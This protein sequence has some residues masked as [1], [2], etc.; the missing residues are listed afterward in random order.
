MPYTKQTRF[1]K[2]AL[3]FLATI[4]LLIATFFIPMPRWA[5][6]L[7]DFVIV[8]G[9]M[10]IRRGYVFFSQGAAYFKAGQEEKAMKKLRAAV[11]AG[12]GA[13]Y[14]IS[15]ASVFV[16]KGAVDEG[17]EILEK[18]LTENNTVTDTNRAKVALSMGK[19]VKGD[20]QRAVEL[21]EQVKE[22]GY[23]DEGLYVNLSTYLLS[24]NQIDK[25]KKV[26]KEADEKGVAL[27]A[28]DDNRGWLDIINGRW[29]KAEQIFDRLINEECVTFPEPYVHGAQ[30]AVHKNEPETAMTYLSWCLARPFSFTSAFT[31]DYVRKLLAG[32]RNTAT[33]K[34]FTAAMEENRVLVAAGK[35]FPGLDKAVFDGPEFQA[36]EQKKRQTEKAS[37]SD[38]TAITADDDDERMPDTELNEDD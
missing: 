16:Q 6:V 29:N 8:G 22:N 35:D 32:I 9:F 7:A 31:T 30:V 37:E 17:I 14:R 21:L 12:I 4:G 27:N 38:S 13:E 20:T 36:P 23:T 25:A 28:M 15:V 3:L 26:I 1:N 10:F 11:R 18:V 19:W 5:R 34:D 33:R 24:D 2:S